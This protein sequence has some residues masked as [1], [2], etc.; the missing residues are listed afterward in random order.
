MFASVFATLFLMVVFPGVGEGRA[1]SIPPYVV[2]DI[3]K[4]AKIVNAFFM[5]AT[6][7]FILVYVIFATAFDTVDTKAV[8]VH[9]DGSESAGKNMTIYV[10]NYNADN[11]R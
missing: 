5:E 11:F 10:I 9:A 2:V 6:L 8:K 7:T 3:N 1:K 4:S